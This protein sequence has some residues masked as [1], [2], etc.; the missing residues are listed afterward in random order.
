MKRAANRALFLF[1]LLC[2]P[3]FGAIQAQISFTRHTLDSYFGAYFIT[4]YDLDR[5]GDLDV[6]SGHG[7]LAWWENDGNGHFTKHLIDNRVSALWSIAP[8]DVNRDGR[9]DLLI[10]DSGNHDI[11]WYKNLGSSFQRIVI[12]SNF[13]NAES[14]CGGD[15]DGDGDIDIAGLTVG[16][17]TSSGIVVWWE[18][19]SFNFRRHDIDLSFNRG[20]KMFSY[21]IDYDGDLD[22]IACAASSKGVTF[23]ENDGRGNFRGHVIY[24]G[25]GVTIYPVDFDKDGKLDILYTQHYAGTVVLIQNRGNGSF[26]SRTLASGFNWPHFAAAGDFNADG[27]LDIAVVTR[28]GNTLEWLENRGGSF[29]RHLIYDNIVGPFSVATGDLDGDG[30]DDIVSG[31]KENMKLWW[32][33]AEGGSIAKT[34]TV[35][36]PNG[37][38]TLDSGSSWQIRWSSTG[39]ISN[40]TIQFS[41]D[42]GSTWS[43]VVSSTSNDGNYTWNVPNVDS[44]HCLIKVLD[45]SGSGA[46]DRSDG[47]FSISRPK[48]IQVLF[49][50]GGEQI[51]GGQDVDIRWSSEGNVQNVSIYYSSD[52]GV[53]WNFIASSSNA[54]QYSWR[55][56]NIISDRCL[57]KVADADGGPSDRSDAPFAISQFQPDIATDGSTW[58]IDHF[59]WKSGGLRADEGWRFT[60]SGEAKNRFS[61]ASEAQWRLVLR[62]KAAYVSTPPQISIRIDGVVF[63]TARVVNKN[64]LEDYVFF[65]KIPAGVHWLTVYVSSNESGQSLT[66][67]SLTFSE[68][69][70]SDYD[71]VDRFVTSVEQVV[72]HPEN[73]DLN[74]WRMD[75]LML[76]M[77]DAYDLLKRADILDYI[78][79]WADTAFDAGGQFTGDLKSDWASSAFVLYWLSKQTGDPKYLSA[80]ST[81]TQNDVNNFPRISNGAFV[82]LARLQDQIWID[83]LHGL[84]YYLLALYYSQQNPYYL[85]ELVNQIKSHAAILQDPATGLFHHAYD[86]DGSAPW[87]DPNTHLSPHFWARGNGWFVM[88]LAD[89]L[90][91][92]PA[93][94]SEQD[95]LDIQDIFIRLARGIKDAQ[96][97]SGL[98][99]TV[100]DQPGREG[101]YLEVSASCLFVAGFQK[102]L[103][104]GILSEAEFGDCVRRANEAITR[105]LYAHPAGKLFITDI[106]GGTSAGSY[107]DYVAVPLSDGHENLYGDGVFLNAKVRS[108]DSFYSNIAQFVVGYV[109]YFV[110]NKGI[111]NV[112]VDLLGN[113]ADPDTLT[114]RNGRFALLPGAGEHRFVF[115]KPQNEDVNG[116]LTFYDAAITARDAVGLENL[117][118]LQRRVADVSQ[119]GHVTAFDAAIIARYAI[120]LPPV[121]NAHPGQWRFEP[122]T[123]VMNSSGLDT[124][125]VNITGYICGDVDGSWGNGPLPKSAQGMEV[126]PA[127]I[128]K[129]ARSGDTLFVRF[130]LPPKRDLLSFSAEFQFTSTK[131][132]LLRVDFPDLHAG[133]SVLSNN[134]QGKIRVGGFGVN[135]ATKNGRVTFVFSVDP[136]VEPQEVHISHVTLN[137][138]PAVFS[139]LNLV[140]EGATPEQP[141]DFVLF[142]NYPNPFNGETVVRYAVP[143]DGWSEISVYDLMGRRIA[144]LENRKVK[145][146]SHTLVWNGRDELG[147]RVPA[148]IYWLRWK[149]NGQTIKILKMTYLP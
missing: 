123:L 40:V 96:D 62:A 44:R 78:R 126:S 98:W 128:W 147:K 138:K 38:E 122:D 105:K 106:S 141:R 112:L 73:Y 27:R 52:N 47:E 50:N 46:A 7:D 67:E 124:Q 16:T 61:F 68:Q 140:I 87:A 10:A 25:S 111:P 33:E 97:A 134:L 32:W 11:V 116:A 129:I 24:G 84:I 20:H 71:W 58:N 110:G 133:W 13:T 41:E 139:D 104:F 6:L 72:P 8:I 137:G 26:S 92:W 76:G 2:T 36:S 149:F 53:N 91:N 29:S 45:A 145:S 99:Y 49:P 118:D 12:Q 83:S 103:H 81:V 34:I 30:D 4:T 113:A 65:G 94:L 9:I 31:S 43:T 100:L 48:S 63:A 146:G 82:H 42:G 77:M 127:D 86:E 35:L 107:N 51:S 89:L 69:A 109:R 95:R 79:R 28:D 23:F 19:Q 74:D 75:V 37:G 120:G 135:P 22:I 117:T 125:F 143:K 121:D 21:D 132:K 108:V 142:P 119:D 114:D 88:A 14:V 90:S 102:A 131:A 54:G 18:N 66:L 101:N 136:Q 70:F 60:G 15:F 1:V 55:V 144:R 59:Y 64:Q 3:F 57:V 115:R 93:Q 5:D 148:G 80:L 130:Q 39:N 56:P 85:D 17:S